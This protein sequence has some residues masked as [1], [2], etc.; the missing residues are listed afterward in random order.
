MACRVFLMLARRDEG[1]WLEAGEKKGRQAL[2]ERR[3]VRLASARR[4]LRNAGHVGL[5]VPGHVLIQFVE[6]T[7]ADHDAVSARR[8]REFVAPFGGGLRAAGGVAWRVC[9]RIV[10][11]S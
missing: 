6:I 2:E 7:V 1:V 5:R 4:Q 10:R 3:D 11:L 8:I 9:R